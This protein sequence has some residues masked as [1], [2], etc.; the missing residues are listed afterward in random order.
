MKNLI[1]SRVSLSVL[2]LAFIVVSGW[3]SLPTSEDREGVL[4]AWA[5]VSPDDPVA[6]ISYLPNEVSNGTWQSLS[7]VGSSSSQGTL[8]NFTWEIEFK[9]TTTFLYT[10][11]DLFKFTDL[12]LYKITL[13]VKD[14]TNRT[15][16]AFSAVF[17]ILDSDGDSLPDW[18]EMYYF[19]DLSET[20]VSDPDKDGY[21][22]LQ[23]YASGTDPT[24]KDPQ[25]GLVEMLARNWI[26]LVIIAAAVVVALIILLPRYKKKQDRDVKKKIEV[27][28][29][30]EKELQKEG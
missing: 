8:V 15:G 2:A 23:E 7:G 4:T 18:W 20:G 13:T 25:P 16:V 1:G 22:N 6:V 30:I 21:T 26:Y 19:D 9:N 5:S 14:S 12:G 10:R 27:A 24:R 3:S 28:I 11:S 17:S 29:E